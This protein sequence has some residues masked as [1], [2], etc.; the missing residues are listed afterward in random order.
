MFSVLH[1]A[2]PSSGGSAFEAAASP[3]PSPRS[4]PLLL[5]VSLPRPSATAR[6]SSRN[7]AGSAPAAARSRC[8]RGAAQY[9]HGSR[10]ASA[11]FALLTIPA[12]A[13]LLLPLL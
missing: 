8:E 12:A 1:A 11:M 9:G 2:A 13:A 3:S 7:A 10:N 5:L 4:P 6:Y